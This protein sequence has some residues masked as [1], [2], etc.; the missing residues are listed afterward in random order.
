[1]LTGLLELYYD[2]SLVDST[3]DTLAGNSFAAVPT[4]LTVG[5]GTLVFDMY[6]LCVFDRTLTSYEITNLTTSLG[7]D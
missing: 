6:D 4:V 3:A 2:G 5:S 1:M 7:L